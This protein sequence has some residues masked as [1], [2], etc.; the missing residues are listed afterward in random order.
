MPIGLNYL[1][2]GVYLPSLAFWCPTSKFCGRLTFS[3]EFTVLYQRSI[4]TF[5]FYEMFLGVYLPS[6]AFY[7]YI[8]ALNLR[9]L[10]SVP[11]FREFR[12]PTLSVLFYSP[13]LSDFPM[14]FWFLILSS[15]LVYHRIFQIAIWQ[16][17]SNSQL[18]FVQIAEIVQKVKLRVYKR[19]QG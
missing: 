2:F 4:L 14:G 12:R 3:L 19:E 15:P 10:W 16:I 17:V 6:L 18:F 9:V 8:K 7:G 5:R 1:S 11:L 13:R